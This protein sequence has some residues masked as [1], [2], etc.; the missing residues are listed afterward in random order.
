MSGEGRGGGVVG[1]KNGLWFEATILFVGIIRRDVIIKPINNYFEFEPE[2]IVM[3]KFTPIRKFRAKPNVDCPSPT[4]IKVINFNMDDPL[5]SWEQP[6][7]LYV[8]IQPNPNDENKNITESIL[9]DDTSDLDNEGEECVEA[10][11]L[12]GTPNEVA[13]DI[14]CEANPDICTPRAPT[15]PESRLKEFVMYGLYMIVAIVILSIFYRCCCGIDGNA[16]AQMKKAMDDL[17]VGVVKEKIPSDAIGAN[18]FLKLAGLEGDEFKLDNPNPLKVAEAEL[19]A[20]KL[21][22]LSQG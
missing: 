22:K 2:T 10:G 1:V 19:G 9:C 20:E 3:S 21:L 13:E 15:L 5:Y 4:R 6:N 18:E 16:M 7:P 8:Q 11:G 17:N 14:F 12:C